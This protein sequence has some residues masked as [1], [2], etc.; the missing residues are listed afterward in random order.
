M[1]ANELVNE[2]ACFQC[3]DPGANWGG[4]V[5]LADQYAETGGPPKAMGQLVIEGDDLVIEGDGIQISI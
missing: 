5:Y 3:T 2:S 1:T 4:A